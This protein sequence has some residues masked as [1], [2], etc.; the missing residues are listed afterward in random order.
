MFEDARLFLV[1]KKPKVSEHEDTW[2]L[3]IIATGH[4]II[5]WG[6]RATRHAQSI[7]NPKSLVI[8]PLKVKEQIMYHQKKGTSM[9]GP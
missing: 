1:G 9:G 5:L 4:S 8:I 6:F 7:D 3:K 2:T